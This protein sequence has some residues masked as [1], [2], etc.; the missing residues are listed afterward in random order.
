MSC[1]RY[2]YE[3][4]MRDLISQ[5]GEEEMQRLLQQEQDNH[6]KSKRAKMKEAKEILKAF[7]KS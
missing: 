3:K 5:L 6:S 2:F 4:G 7:K 1:L